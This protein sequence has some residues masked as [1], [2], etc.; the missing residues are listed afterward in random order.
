MNDND[1]NDLRESIVLPNARDLSQQIL[2]HPEQGKIWLDQQRVILQTLPSLAATWREVFDTMGLQRTRELYMRSG[3][4]NGQVDAELALKS[5][6]DASPTDLFLAGPQLHMLRGMAEI[7]PLVL[8]LDLGTGH[9]YMDSLCGDCFEVEI[10]LSEIGT[11]DQPVCWNLL[12]YASGFSSCIMGKEILFREIECRGC[13][14]TRCRVIGK[15]IADWDNAD[16]YDIFSSS[17]SLIETLYHLQAKLA[18]QQRNQT[19]E[20]VFSTLIGRSKNFQK[21]C[22]MANKAAASR[23][24]VLLTG[25]TGVGKEL[26]AKGIHEKSDRSSGPF[27]AVNCAA[28]PSELIEAELFGVEKGAYTGAVN[29]RKGRFERAD[30]GTIFLDEVV[31]LSPRAQ[32]SLLRIL[33]EKEF[34]RVGDYMTRKVNVRLVAAT[35]EDLEEAVKLGKFRADLYYRLN[36]FPLLIPPL[37]GRKD[38]IPLLIEHFIEKYETQYA[39]KTLGLTDRALNTL[40]NYNWPGNIRELENV[41]ERSLILTERNERIRIDAL[42]PE[43]MECDQPC[44]SIPIDDVIPT[45]RADNLHPVDNDDW[46]DAILQQSICIGD[47]EERLL[48]KA[49]QATNNNASKAARM[50]GLSRSAFT[51]RYSKLNKETSTK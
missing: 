39:K 43:I 34:E 49:M 7:Q 2:F 51:Y 15:P 9:F 50:L 21:M 41:I 4:R 28:I 48:R 35:N 24:T 22:L 16:D 12:G 8:E 36:V 17:D 5:R 26:V 32:S 6:R 27:M 47:V 1:K 19:D 25:E 30:G 11:Q 40:L 42:F 33:Q 31:E 44:S 38:D 13:G 18:D 14:D 23:A 29:T 3:F 46:A 37:R 10:V 45:H 20:K